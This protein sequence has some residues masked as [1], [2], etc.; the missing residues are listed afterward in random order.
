MICSLTDIYL[1]FL[2]LTEVT[3]ESI[4]Y[5]LV[6]GI[7]FLYETMMSFKIEFHNICSF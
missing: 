6:Y 3:F 2:A 1:R 7:V 4:W 5:F